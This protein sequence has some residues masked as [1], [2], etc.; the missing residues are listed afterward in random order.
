MRFLLIPFLALMAF[1]AMAQDDVRFNL[2]CSEFDDQRPQQLRTTID[3]EFSI[4]LETMTVCRG[5]NTRCWDI[6]RQGRFLEL[7]YPFSDGRD[8]YEMFRLYDPQTGWLTQ[9][10]R[11]VG[12]PGGSYGEAVCQ[13][14]PFASVMD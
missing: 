2:K 5:G 4:D 6:V 10:I 7:T 13:V 9:V 11:I 8:D 3:H 1:P 12:Q 14:H